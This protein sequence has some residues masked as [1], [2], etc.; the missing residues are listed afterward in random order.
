VFFID[1][2]GHQKDET[3]AQALADLRS[4]TESMRVMGS[5]PRDVKT[6]RDIE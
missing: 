3:V 5:Y 2:E 4:H 6:V 1:M